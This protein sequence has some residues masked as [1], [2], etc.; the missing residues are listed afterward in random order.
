[1]PE[2]KKRITIYGGTERDG[3]VVSFSK[4]VE[5]GGDFL[6]FLVGDTVRS[7]HDT[8]IFQEGS[9][10]VVGWNKKDG[11]IFLSKTGLNHVCNEPQKLILLARDW[12]SFQA[13]D[14]VQIAGRREKYK[15]VCLDPKGI[16][17]LVRRFNLLCVEGTTQ[18]IT[19]VDCK[20]PFFPRNIFFDYRFFKINDLKKHNSKH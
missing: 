3:R 18:N 8:S 12:F 5:I 9:W 11:C 10:Q 19:P 15:I 2:R 13:G 16:Y 20:I 4:E 17:C 1:M 14:K 7:V 6:G